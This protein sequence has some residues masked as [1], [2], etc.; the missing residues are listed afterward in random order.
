MIVY[1]IQHE[2]K[3][4]STQDSYKHNFDTVLSYQT[5]DENKSTQDCKEPGYLRHKTEDF[6]VFNKKIV[7]VSQQ[8]TVNI[9]S[10][11]RISRCSTTD[12]RNFKEENSQQRKDETE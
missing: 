6:V 12:F 7:N 2:L 3:G 9:D 11:H 1:L 8:R 10:Q 4:Q 5:G